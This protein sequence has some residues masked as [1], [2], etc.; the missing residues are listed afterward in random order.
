MK[1]KL[2][3]QQADLTLTPQARTRKAQDLLA[4]AMGMPRGGE[5]QAIG[6]LA[7]QMQASYDARMGKMVNDLAVLLVDHPRKPAPRS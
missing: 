7:D 3:L 6:D 1:L 5:L 2:E 4:K